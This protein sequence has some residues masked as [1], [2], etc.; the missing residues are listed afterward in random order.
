MKTKYLSVRA[1]EVYPYL[2]RLTSLSHT[3]FLLLYLLLGTHK[4][5]CTWQKGGTSPSSI[6]TSIQLFGWWMWNQICIYI[7]IYIYKNDMYR[8][9]GEEGSR[10][11]WESSPFTCKSHSTVNQSL[12]PGLLGRQFSHPSHHLCRDFWVSHDGKAEQ[13][14]IV[15]KDEVQDFHPN[16]CGSYLNFSLVDYKNLRPCDPQGSLA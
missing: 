3:L 1:L 13:V 9:G 2:N 14:T 4:N 15:Q 12:Y 10:G 16:S 8:N 6:G 11:E 7:Y 5:N